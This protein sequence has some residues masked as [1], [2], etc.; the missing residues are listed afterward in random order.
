M[1]AAV[2]DAFLTKGTIAQVVDSVESD[3]PSTD[4]FGLW[5][6]RGLAM[7]YGFLKEAVGSMKPQEAMAQMPS[8]GHWFNAAKGEL[9]YRTNDP[10]AHRALMA[11]GYAEWRLSL[12]WGAE[13]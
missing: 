5:F 6:A 8:Q 2:A 11:L 3:F 9:V 12:T 10:H 13:F 4:A 1:N 7:Q